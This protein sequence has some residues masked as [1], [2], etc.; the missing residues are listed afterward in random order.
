MGTSPSRKLLGFVNDVSHRDGGNRA[1][2][3][4]LHR[5][6]RGVRSAALGARAVVDVHA[7]EARLGQYQDRHVPAHLCRIE[8][9]LRVNEVRRDLLVP[10][11]GAQ[12]VLRERRV[13][14]GTHNG[15]SE[16]GGHRRYCRTCSRGAATCR[17]PSGDNAVS[18][19]RP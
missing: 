19:P 15:L 3:G 17:A 6:R 14:A 11:R 5:R 13:V 1:E 4:A 12:N 8:G 16:S 7:Q 2:L 10:D 9:G 18:S